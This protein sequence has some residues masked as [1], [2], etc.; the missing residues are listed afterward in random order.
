MTINNVP[1]GRARLG[2]YAHSWSAGRTIGN[3]RARRWL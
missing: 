1:T 2:R 3:W